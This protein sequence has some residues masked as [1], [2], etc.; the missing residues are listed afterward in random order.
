[1][2]WVSR[3]KEVAP[4]KLKKCTQCGVAHFC[5]K[6]C[7][8]LAWN[9][10]DHKEICPKLKQTRKAVKA[11]G[12]SKQKEASAAR[13]TRKQMEGFAAGFQ[14]ENLP[15]VAQGGFEWPQAHKYE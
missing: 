15:F 9:A 11:N 10:L 1:M 5:G 7:M 4:N 14:R 8:K 13:Q 3:H 6:E 2:Q 12:Y